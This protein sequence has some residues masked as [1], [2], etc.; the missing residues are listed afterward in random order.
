MAFVEGL[1][2]ICRQLLM[3]A[4]LSLFMEVLLPGGELKK[5]AQFVMGLLVV[6]ALLNPLLGLTKGL[7]PDVVAK[8]FM[9]T[10][11]EA[12]QADIRDNT[13]DIITAGSSLDSSAQ[14]VAAQQLADSLERQIASLCSLAAGVEDSRVQVELNDDITA[15]SGGVGHNWGRVI[16]VLTVAADAQTEKE[17][18]C[19]E[20]RQTVA[21]FYDIE[22]GA[23]QVS[24]AEY[25]ES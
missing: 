4:G 9:D 21:D 15:G 24:V 11:A 1:S 12:A 5:Y 17:T 10:F 18:V 22:P 20:I 16:I 25:G 13:D 7:A 2:E 23:V 19:R 3:L 6:A 8:V 14:I